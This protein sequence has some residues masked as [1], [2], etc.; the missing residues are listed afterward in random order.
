MAAGAMLI[1]LGGSGALIQ[2][3]RRRPWADVLDMIEPQPPQLPRT[4]SGVKP[5]LV[6]MP[7]RCICTARLSFCD[8]AIDG[9]RN[10]RGA[11][12]ARASRAA[13]AWGG[14]IFTDTQ[15]GR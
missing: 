5:P 2:W 9:V 12:R 6:V 4:G 15:R 11:G 13:E 7:L 3:M 10:P 14:D 8:C 1:A